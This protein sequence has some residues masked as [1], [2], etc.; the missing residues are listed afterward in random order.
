MYWN[1]HMTTAGWTF[2]LLGSILIAV[3]G[4]MVWLV[5]MLRSR[6]TALPSG[7][8]AREILNR[9]LANGELTI[10]QHE[11]LRDAMDHGAASTS[12]APRP[13]ASSAS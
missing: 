7:L 1:H 13:H 10:E 3:A 6:D 11:Q 12:S 5:S 8:S 9:R 4:A 2:S